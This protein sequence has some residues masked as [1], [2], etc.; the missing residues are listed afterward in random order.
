[1]QRLVAAMEAL[2]RIEDTQGTNAKIELMR[3]ELSDDTFAKVVQYCLSTDKTFNVKSFPKWDDAWSTFAHKFP[4]T[5]DV[6]DH[7]DYLDNKGSASKEDKEKLFQMART[8][9]MIY[10]LLWRICNSKLKC[11]CAAKNVNKAIPG[12]IFLMPYMRCKSYKEVHRIKWDQGVLA[13]LKADGMFVNI[14]VSKKGKIKFR[15]RDGKVVHQLKHLKKQLKKGMSK[16][17][18]GFVYHG[19]LLISE[20]GTIWPRKKGNGVFNSCIQNKC[21]PSTAKM[22]VIQLWDAVPLDDFWNH[23][24]SIRNIERFN[25]VKAFVEDIKCPGI[26]LIDSRIVHSKEE[27][28]KFFIEMRKKKREGVILKNFDGIW[29]YHTSPD[30]VKMKNISDCD[31]RV[32]GWY[33]GKKGKYK[34]MVGGFTYSSSCGTV[35]G[36]CGSGLED[37]ERTP[38][39]WDSRIDSIATLEF[40]GIEE[41]KGKEGYR[42]YLPIYVEIRGDKDEADDL[43]AIREALASGT[44]ETK[45]S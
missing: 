15:S 40:E 12:S 33:E 5:K 13:Q 44:A 1:M 35:T 4:S 34:G 14:I 32:T 24:C 7:L 27:A 22:A 38:E 8:N 17:H 10:E 19:E 23:K 31:V 11:G 2:R 43:E 45:R 28:T 42:L 21:D 25:H 6:F 9:K 41:A 36:K 18:Y 29:A 3:K 16:E 20:N 37:S 39:V 30:A 26:S